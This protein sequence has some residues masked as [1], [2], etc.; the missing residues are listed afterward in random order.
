MKDIH[1]THKKSLLW[2]FPGRSQETN[3]SGIKKLILKKG[4]FRFEYPDGAKVLYGI[5]L[6]GIPVIGSLLPNGT[7]NWMP[8]ADMIV[9]TL[10]KKVPEEAELPTPQVSRIKVNET[11]FELSRFSLGSKPAELIMV[12]F[13]DKGLRI[14]SE[15]Y[16]N[17]KELV[18][19]FQAVDELPLSVFGYSGAFYISELDGFREVLLKRGIKVPN[20]CTIPWER[21][22]LIAQSYLRNSRDVRFVL[23]HELGHVLD[24]RTFGSLKF[25]EKISDEN[26]EKLFG[27]GVLVK[28]EAEKMDRKKSDYF[29][30]YAATNEREDF[31]ETYLTLMMLRLLFNNMNPG[32]DLLDLPTTS[33]DE[34]LLTRNFTPMQHK[35]IWAVY[36]TIYK[37]INP[38]THS[39]ELLKEVPQERLISV[40]IGVGLWHLL[41][42][43]YFLSLSN[44]I[45]Q[46]RQKSELKF[47]GV[48]FARNYQLK[49]KAYTIFIKDEPVLCRE[50]QNFYAPSKDFQIAT[51][52]LYLGGFEVYAQIENLKKSLIQEAGKTIAQQIEKSI[53]SWVSFQ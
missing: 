52:T 2:V 43:K 35:K 10:E 36:K 41:H 37:I 44:Q 12:R 8:N 45:E 20:A 5:K 18:N 22:V 48:K 46:V 23:Y 21:S 1:K 26:G 24:S 15:F 30:K 51:L 13:K 25:S 6:K 38:D 28:N 16:L 4:V 50:V 42:P 17:E 19:F 7:E 49:P 27:K 14:V 29:S 34:F 3:A 9:H 40:E 33:L 32:M 53:H 39:E 11:V 47:S 31:A